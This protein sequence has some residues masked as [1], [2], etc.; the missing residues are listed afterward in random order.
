GLADCAVCGRSS[1][2]WWAGAAFAVLDVAPLAVST[3]MAGIAVVLNAS[4]AVALR[5]GRTP[6]GE[7]IDR[8]GRFWPDYLAYTVCAAGLVIWVGMAGP[9]WLAMGVWL[10]STITCAARWWTAHPV[11]PQVPALTPPEPELPEPTEH[12]DEP[13]G[14]AVPEALD[15]YVL[16]WDQYA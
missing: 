3:I 12:T 7:R 4:V 2:P 11:G 16:A 1:V 9:S 13:D 10:L 5:F 14:S 6:S 8:L 15:E